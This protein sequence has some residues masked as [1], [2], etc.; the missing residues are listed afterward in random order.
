MCCMCVCLL[1][2]RT[3]HV[4]SSHPR[5]H[6]NQLKACSNTVRGNASL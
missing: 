2:E 4:T 5:S 3:L 1:A 6:M